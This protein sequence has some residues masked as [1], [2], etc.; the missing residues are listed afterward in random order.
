ML[1]VLRFT[2]IYRDI[3]TYSTVLSR[4]EIEPFY[5]VSRYVGTNEGK[6]TIV[7]I[8]TQQFTLVCNSEICTVIGMKTNYNYYPI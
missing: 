8:M 6:A 5:K 1:F 2:S 3:D 7:V 4:T